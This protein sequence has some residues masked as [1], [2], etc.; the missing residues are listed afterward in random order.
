MLSYQATLI[1]NLLQGKE[2]G[3]PGI[4]E[5]F[6]GELWRLPTG[7][8]CASKEEEFLGWKPQM[9]ISKLSSEKARSTSLSPPKNP[10]DQLF[11]CYE[12]HCSTLSLFEYRCLVS[13]KTVQG[14]HLHL[15]CGLQ[16]LFLSPPDSDKN[17]ENREVRI[18][19]APLLAWLLQ[20][21]WER[22]ESAFSSLLFLK[23]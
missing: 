20:D 17:K 3:A 10:E 23:F 1:C 8:W 19:K 16:R 15:F 4:S 5:I 7:W 18:L 6:T 9:S 22:W 14:N 13:A 2:S 12:K 21:S 11:L